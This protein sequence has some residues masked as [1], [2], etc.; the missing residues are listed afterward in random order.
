MKVK[1]LLVLLLFGLL[2]TAATGSTVTEVSDPAD[3]NMIL[4][5]ISTPTIRPGNDGTL[6]YVVSN[7][8]EQEMS[9]VRLTIEQYA[10]STLDYEKPINEIGSPPVFVSSQDIYVSFTTPALAPGEERTIQHRLEAVKNTP[11]GVY[12]LRFQLLFEYNG[13]EVI[14]RSRGYFTDDEWDYAQRRP[15]TADEPYYVHSLNITHLGVN[16]VIHDSSFT[17]KT[18][19]PRWPQYALGGAAGLFGILAAMLYMQE[20]Y[21]SFPWLEKTLDD[22]SGKFKEFRSRFEHGPGKG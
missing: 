8:Y 11:E 4:P 7:P 2:F 19:I 10:F 1:I 18:P 16:G 13:E 22:W 5:D 14:M 6:S 12:F 15:G 21:N 9:S 20:E 17:V 3:V